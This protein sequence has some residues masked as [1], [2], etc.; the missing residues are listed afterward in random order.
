[1]PAFIRSDLTDDEYVSLEKLLPPE[2]S[3]Q[4]GRPFCSHRQVLNGIFWIHRTGAPWR[5]LPDYYGPWT[6]VY[7]RFRR[8]CQGGLW[9]EILNRLQ[10]QGRQLGRIDF[11]FAAVDGSVVRAHK[12][13]SG[14]RRRDQDP[15][16]TTVESREKQALGF[17]R[18]GFSTK[19]HVLCEGQ[20]K[21]ITIALTPGQVHENTQVD[22]LLD[23]VR[24][25][26]LPGRP[27]QCFAC[28]AGDK[29][30]DSQAI[31]ARLRQ[32]SIQPTIA[33]RKRPDGSYPPDA[34][35]FD[36]ESYRQ[37]N[38]VERLIGKLKEFRRI[39]KRFEK[40]ADHFLSMVQIG[41]MRIW[42]KDL[43]SYT[44]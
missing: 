35:Y 26:G 5:D 31:R 40:L 33:H 23:S 24:I 15:P 9:T 16:L 44:A 18:G 36:K 41:F 34:A 43:L 1:M 12:A 28:L 38:V 10:A 21:P 4:A 3:G 29:G 39:A 30:Y 37:R 13:A 19:L 6:T 32:R 7:D 20:G 2:R 42:L 27:R 8:W 22:R 14:A 17:S 11:D 25:A